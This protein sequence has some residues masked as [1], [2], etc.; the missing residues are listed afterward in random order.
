MSKY[1]V[2]TNSDS[3]VS[4]RFVVLQSGY[5]PSLESTRTLK[6]TIN[7]ERDI[8]F[9]DVFEVHRYVI[10]VLGGDFDEY[11]V[12][13][14]DGVL[15]DL[16]LFYSYVNP[17]GVPSPVLILTDHKGDDHQVVIADNDFSEVP[18]TTSIEGSNAVFHVTCTFAFLGAS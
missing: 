2:L 6:K 10:R 9:G 14:S 16:K 8:S 4:R 18:L 12:P 11:A 1:I 13:G 15:D 3:S 5:K 7:G 17:N